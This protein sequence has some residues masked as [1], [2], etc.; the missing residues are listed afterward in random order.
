MNKTTRGK[1]NP[2]QLAYIAG[3]VD[4][5]GSIFI[6]KIKVSPKRNYKNPQHILHVSV[7]NTYHDVI[8]WL[9]RH[10]NEKAKMLY[11][12]K[13]EDYHREVAVF[14]VSGL[15]ALYFLEEIYPYLKVKKGQAKLAIQ[16]QQRKMKEN[17][18]GIKLTIKDMQ[19]REQYREKIMVLNNSRIL[20]S[21]N[22]QA[23]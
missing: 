21:R 7:V 8:H 6:T 9:N 20:R 5:E 18:G 22:E 10:Y 15:N 3:F 4:G 1:L 17:R 23:R 19:W 11:K 2:L 14:L 16:F 13:A 12:P